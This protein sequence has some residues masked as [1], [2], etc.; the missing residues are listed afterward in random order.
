MDRPMSHVQ[1][2]NRKSAGLFIVPEK[3]LSYSHPASAG[4][5]AKQRTRK[6][7]QRFP[8]HLNKWNAERRGLQWREEN[9]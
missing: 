7:F 4:W 3:G 6:P 9:P 2:P 1:Y 8:E 5:P